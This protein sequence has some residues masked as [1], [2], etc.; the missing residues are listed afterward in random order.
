MEWMMDSWQTHSYQ[1]NSQLETTE[2]TSNLIEDSDR[3]AVISN[4]D[5]NFTSQTPAISENTGDVLGDAQ[6]GDGNTSTETED[7]ATLFKDHL[8]IPVNEGSSTKEPTTEDT[9]TL[10]KDE[11]KIQPAAADSPIRL[12]GDISADINSIAPHT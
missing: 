6:L 10:S 2:V 12:S 9:E 1:L 5:L 4:E 3:N 7:I 8:D 11:L